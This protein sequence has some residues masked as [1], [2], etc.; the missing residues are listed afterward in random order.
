MATSTL[1]SVEEYLRLPPR[2]DGL[3]EELIEGEIVLSPS[4]KPLHAKIIANLF[5]LLRPLTA[6]GF[7]RATDF[8]CQL[9]EHSLPGPDL[10]AIRVGRWNAVGED[11]YLVGSPELVVEVFSPSNRKALIV[12]KAALYLQYGAEAVWVVYPKERTVVVHEGDSQREAR[13]GE[14]VSFGGVDLP[15]SAIFEGL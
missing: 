6:Q 12:Q 8:G 5:D 11:E 3:E 9:G 13:C 15:V 7:A 4:A 2:E 14:T 1:L 10:A